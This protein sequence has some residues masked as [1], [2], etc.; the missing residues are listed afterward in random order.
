[1]TNLIQFENVRKKF[2][3]KQVLKEINFSIKKGE[4]KGLVGANGA[5]KTTLMRILVGLTK[6]YEGSVYYKEQKIEDNELS[7]GC[8]IESPSFYPYMTGKQNL[9]F[10]ATLTGN[11]TT[12][13]IEDVLQLLGISHAANKKVKTYSLGMRQRLGIAQALIGNPDIL[14][15]DEPTN[16][17][18]PQGVKEMRT[19]LHHI[20]KDRGIAILISSH[21]LSEIEKMCDKVMLLQDGELIEDMSSLV[22][23]NQNEIEYA[24]ETEYG[25]EMVAFFNQHQISNRIEDELV[26]AK[27]E[28]KNLSNILKNLLTEGIAFERI[29]ERQESLEDQFIHLLGGNKK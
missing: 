27:M 10:F 23:V 12:T 14:V 28:K 1:M 19:Y 6:N 25:Q 9:K 26:I 16:G 5:G 4:V 8:V 29:N 24:F 15:L 2:Q 18:D 13:E 7:V 20:S 17:L 11:V 3:D 21:I 22:S